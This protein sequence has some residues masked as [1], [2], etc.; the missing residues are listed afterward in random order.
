MGPCTNLTGGRIITGTGLSASILSFVNRTNVR[1]CYPYFTNDEF[2]FNNTYVDAFST[3][4]SLQ[5]SVALLYHNSIPNSH[6]SL[7]VQCHTKNW[8]S[9][10]SA[11]H[12]CTTWGTLASDSNCFCSPLKSDSTVNS[13]TD[14]Y[15]LNFPMD[16]L[17][18]A[19]YPTKLWIEFSSGDI[20][21]L[22]MK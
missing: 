2:D 9:K 22:D 4:F 14:N 11:L 19:A 5:N 6:I 12:L 3:S 8:Y 20:N 13:S 18:A 21:D 1:W 17:T 10:N 7:A 16:Q 15:F